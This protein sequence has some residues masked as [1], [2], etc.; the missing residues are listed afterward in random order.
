MDPVACGDVNHV[1]LFV[2]PYVFVCMCAHVRVRV[3]VKFLQ[4]KN[5][6]S[7]AESLPPPLHI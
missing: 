5:K 7:K 1:N 6:Y 4:D 3:R 2:S